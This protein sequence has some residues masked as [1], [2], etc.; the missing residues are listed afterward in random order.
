MRRVPELNASHSWIGY[1]PRDWGYSIPKR[2]YSCMG[3]RRVFLKR[4]SPQRISL[5]N[6]HALHGV[7]TLFQISQDV[8][9]ILSELHLVPWLSPSLAANMTEPRSWTLKTVMIITE[10]RRRVLVLLLVSWSFREAASEVARDF[11]AGRQAQDQ[12]QDFEA[13]SAT[14]AGK[15]NLKH[16]RFQ[17]S[18]GP[19]RQVTRR[20]TC[21]ERFLELTL[22]KHNSQPQDTVVF[23]QPQKPGTWN[24]NDRQLSTYLFS[25]QAVLKWVNYGLSSPLQAMYVSTPIS[26]S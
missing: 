13:I 12:A 24:R 6:L 4:I 7:A 9:P 15:I 19:D 10:K 25:F 3:R 16:G 8:V 2:K 14:C 17:G 23:P 11:R 20:K 26:S 1:A 18:D 5:A 21:V 22:Y